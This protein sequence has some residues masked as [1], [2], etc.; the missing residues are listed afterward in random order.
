MC[1]G[2]GKGQFFANRESDSTKSTKSKVHTTASI[3]DLVCTDRLGVASVR[4]PFGC[5]D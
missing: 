3:S 1:S 4:G 2:V 5:S